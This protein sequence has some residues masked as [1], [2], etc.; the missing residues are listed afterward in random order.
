MNMPGF[1]PLSISL[2]RRAFNAAGLTTGLLWL[3]GCQSRPKAEDIPGPARPA[4]SPAP[5]TGP[6]TR[7][8]V[9]TPAPAP[10][11]VPVLPRAM[12]T[13]AGVARMQHINPMNGVNRITVHHD[14]MTPFTSTSQAD[15]ARRI[16]Q[17]R[18]AHLQRRAKTGEY[19]AD[20]GY[21]YVIDPGGRVWEARSIQY[22]GA[23]VQDQNEHNLGVMCLG[24]YDQQSPA[25]A[26]LASL[27]RFIADQMRRYRVP[28]GRVYTHQ[29][30][31]PTA[32]PG[33]S[34]QRYL[35]STRA[36]G[37]AMR[38]AIAADAP[39]LA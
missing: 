21:H 6:L 1:D 35:V 8:P 29:E 14:G 11:S 16:E 13:S 15:A 36:P 37:G 38:V 30:I 23:H 27:D 33:R 12:W 3:A 7:G 28:I 20:I 31:N 34:L 17:I 18:Q 9:P 26:T 4:G 32:C 10:G 5:T 24:N 19:W 2:S 39:A 25:P 22:Q